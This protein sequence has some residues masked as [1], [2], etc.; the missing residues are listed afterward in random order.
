MLQ[1]AW[2]VCMSVS[3]C[4]GHADVLRKKGEEMKCHLR[5]MTLRT[6]GTVH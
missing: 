1:I 5:G 2:S 4:V 3:L 6:K